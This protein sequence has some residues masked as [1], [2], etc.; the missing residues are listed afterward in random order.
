M[1]TKADLVDKLSQP[2]LRLPLIY[3]CYPETI[4]LEARAMSKLH[5]LFVL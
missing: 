3:P 2:L 4:A 5:S 1:E